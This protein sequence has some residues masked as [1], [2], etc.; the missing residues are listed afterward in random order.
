MSLRKKLEDD[1]RE[2][3]EEIVGAIADSQFLQRFITKLGEHFDFLIYQ[4]MLID[5]EQR[6]FTGIP[7]GI[8][9]AKNS[10]GRLLKEA[11]KPAEKDKER[12]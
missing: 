2:L 5:Q 3:K 8:D 4:H 10:L 1:H 7:E 6:Q 11:L 9:K 12:R